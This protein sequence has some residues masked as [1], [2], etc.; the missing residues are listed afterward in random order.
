M[1]GRIEH[2]LAATIHALGYVQRIS[3][4]IRINFNTTLQ[5]FCNFDNKHVDIIPQ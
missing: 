2:N 5:H 1:I 3:R 4:V